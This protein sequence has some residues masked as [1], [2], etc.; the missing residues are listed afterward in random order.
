MQDDPN[1]NHRSKAPSKRD[2]HA[3]YSRPG[4]MIRRAHQIAVSLFESECSSLGVT[5]TQYG[6]MYILRARP[7]IDQ[8]TLAGLIGFD[9][10][11]TALVVK[12][13]T[14]AGFATRSPSLDDRRR[15]VLRLTARGE[16]VLA[17]LKKPAR[18]AQEHLL[19]VFEPAEAT[20]FM[21]L[22]A[23]LVASFNDSVRT[24]IF[25]EN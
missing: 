5:N 8:V 22:L 4:F 24:P 20:M 1:M 10:S 18:K 13:L 6:V 17:K 3:L 21:S 9:R 2:L 19:A 11:T 12:K 23:R 14:D 16:E 15:N 25:P 7:G